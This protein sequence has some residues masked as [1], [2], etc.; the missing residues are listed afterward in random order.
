[1]EKWHTLKERV[2]NFAGWIGEE[3]SDRM[4]KR[5]KAV[6]CGVCAALM[7]AGCGAAGD[8]IQKVEQED[9]AEQFPPEEEDAGSEKEDADGAPEEEQQD[10]TQAE[11]QEEKEASADLP[12]VVIIENEEREYTEGDKV[13]LTASY[14]HVSVTVEEN[15]A[16]TQ[17][18][19]AEFEKR[20]KAFQESVAE[21]VEW[22][23]EDTLVMDSGMSYSEQKGY[24]VKRNDGHILS[25]AT[26][27][28][29]F[30]GGAHGY[31]MDYGLNFDA[32]TGQVLTIADIAQD[33]AAFQEICV[34]EMLRQCE[35]LRAE[36]L[37]FDDEMLDAVGGLQGILEG[38]M[39]GEEWYFTEEGIC[40]I[41]NIYEIA[42]YAAGNFLFDIPYEMID[43]T[44][45][46]EYRGRSD[47]EAG[48]S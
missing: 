10:K 9:M 19:M 38:K 4:T 11:E 30:E 28:G 17:A 18:I 3:E 25:F 27:S 36:G 47:Q 39:E 7:L 24:E 40:F 43:E 20:E 31:Y 29:G 2:H 46:E 16:A 26:G 21:L 6:L 1:M 23:K 14:D 33:E 22:A 5:W 34:Q 37:L 32:K 45:K 35:D 12:A 13:V 44:L 48:A 8:D 41:S 15:E 42:P